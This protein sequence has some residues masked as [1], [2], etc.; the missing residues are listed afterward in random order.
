MS[1][2]IKKEVG[3][4]D[5]YKG[6]HAIS[7]IKFRYAAKELG[8]SAWG[9]NVLEIDANCSAYPEH[10]H[11]KDGQEE[12]YTVLK[13]SATLISEGKEWPLKVGSLIKVGPGTKRKILPG[14]DG[15]TILAI[16]GTPGK[17]YQRA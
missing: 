2:V 5:Y 12:V 1:D 9:M 16:G 10:D 3:E 7:G 11:L 8:V 15:V 4:L 17:A 13:G 14:K 6:E